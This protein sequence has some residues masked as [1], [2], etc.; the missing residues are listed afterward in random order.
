MQLCSLRCKIVQLFWDLTDLSRLD[1]SH[2]WRLLQTFSQSKQVGLAKLLL[3]S[4]T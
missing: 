2:L 1:V 3:W 4:E